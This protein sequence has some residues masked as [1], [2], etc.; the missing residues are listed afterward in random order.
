M[1]EITWLLSP[2][3]V[4]ICPVLSTLPW[5]RTVIFGNLLLSASSVAKWGLLIFP[6]PPRTVTKL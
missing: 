4:A 1:P 5:N 3:R 6:L 2:V